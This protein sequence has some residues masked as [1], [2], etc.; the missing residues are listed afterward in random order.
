MDRIRRITMK[1]VLAIADKPIE[2]RRLHTCMGC[3]WFRDVICGPLDKLQFDHKEYGR[4]SYLQAALRDV[5]Y[6]DCTIYTA[7][8]HK[9][10]SLHVLEVERVEDE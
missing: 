5:E 2:N 3:E 7:M 4:I 9:R 6:H 8:L 10:R 1:D